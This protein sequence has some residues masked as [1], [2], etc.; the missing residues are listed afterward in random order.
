MVRRL[1]TKWI[2]VMV[3][4]HVTQSTHINTLSWNAF[5]INICEEIPSVK[6]ITNQNEHPCSYR[7]G[8]VFQWVARIRENKKNNHL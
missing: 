6:R 8:G 1:T 3:F 2:E 5:G 7:K 4:I